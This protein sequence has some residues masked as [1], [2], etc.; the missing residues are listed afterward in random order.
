MDPVFEAQ[1]RLMREDFA[2]RR[3]E[4]EFAQGSD[5]E[6]DYLYRT[7]RL[8]TVATTENL[9]ALGHATGGLR[10]WNATCD[11]TGGS[12]PSRPTG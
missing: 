4:V 12:P 6:V 1:F 11:R 9:E 7:D 8:L 5:G 2:R 3:I 10:G